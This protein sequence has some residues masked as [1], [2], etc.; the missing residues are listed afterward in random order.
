MRDEFLP[1]LDDET[2]DVPALDAALT[3]DE[4]DDELD[5]GRC[6]GER[7]ALVGKLAG[8][9]KKEAAALIRGEGGL[10][11]DGPDGKTTWIVAGEGESPLPGSQLVDA[12]ERFFGPEVRQAID[13]G[14]IRLTGE[15]QLW[16]R[17]GLVDVEQNIQRLYTPQMLAELLGVAPALIRRWHKRGLITPTREVKKL[18]YFDFAE[19]AAARRLAE[20]L[21][22]GLSPAELENRI[23]AWSKYLPQTGRPLEQLALIVRGKQLLVRQDDGLVGPGGQLFF[24]FSPEADQTRTEIADAAL[25]FPGDE[26]HEAAPA[27]VSLA[28]IRAARANLRCAVG[29]HAA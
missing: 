17:L 23:A 14:H 22:T 15:T 2:D 28:E 24:D 25:E 16:E 11:V 5:R 12:L 26:G 4:A 13:D 19:V 29:R 8:M 21:A 10:V 9:S 27:V 3:P 1:A 7:V 20:L 6:A 18:P